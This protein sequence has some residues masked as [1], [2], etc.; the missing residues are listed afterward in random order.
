[1]LYFHFDPYSELAPNP[2]RT[3]KIQN[4]CESAPYAPGA[5][6]ASARFERSCAREAEHLTQLRPRAEVTALQ[7]FRRFGTH[8]PVG[9]AISAIDMAAWD[10]L[11]RH[12]TNFGLG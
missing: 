6:P 12:G 10:P 7:T 5:E 11:A 2:L 9:I 4:P 1:M 3:A 8:G